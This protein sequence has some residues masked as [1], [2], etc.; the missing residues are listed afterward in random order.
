MKKFLPVLFLI[1]LLL[2]GCA[3]AASPVTVTVMLA[4][5]G[6]FTVDGEN[7]M[8]VRPG[9]DAVFRLSLS[10]D[11]VVFDADGGVWDEKN[12]TLTVPAVRFPATLS[13]R[14]IKN[15]GKVLFK[16]GDITGKGTLRT[17]H[18]IG[19]Y[20]RGTEITLEAEA[21]E[22]WI[23]A[24]WKK[25]YG[26]GGQI[27]STD[28]V[29]AFTLEEN[30][31]LTPQFLSENEAKKA[32]QVNILY[33]ANG[34][35]TRDGGDI[36]MHTVTLGIAKLPNLLPEQGYFKRDGHILIEYNTRA[37]GTGTGYSLGSKYIAGEGEV[38][39]TLYCIWA[40]ESDASLFKY[41]TEGGKA[42]ITSY[43]GN[44]D[45]VVIPSKLGGSPVT[46]IAKDAFT[47]RK[48]HTVV[49]PESM[50]TVEKGAFTGCPNFTTLY[51]FDTVEMIADNSFTNLSKF[52]NFRLNAAM[53][54]R[55]AGS[56]E[57][58]F[59]VKWEKLVTTQEKN[60]VVVMSGSSS[61]YGLS[62][63]LF[64]ELLGGKYTVVNYG[65]NAGTSSSFYMEVCSH[66]MHEGDILIQ[67][68][69][70]SNS[71]QHGINEITWRLLRGTE[72]YYNVFRLVDM[73]QYT[74]LFSAFTDYNNERK[75]MKDSSYGKADS[76]MDLNGDIIKKWPMNDEKYEWTKNSTPN[77]N[78]ITATFKK[79]LD[80]VHK[81]L[82]D[83]GATVYFSYGISNRNSYKDSALTSENLAKVDAGY[84]KQLTVP[85]ISKIE[86]YI[87]EGKYMANSSAHLND[88]GRTIRTQRLARD[89]LA[90]LEKDG[91]K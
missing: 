53:N 62:T 52:A 35:K 49:F 31:Q 50:R 78:R 87:F 22:G 57:G 40:K 74:K 18:E 61:L 81:M 29:Y 90:Q 60:R 16:T 75:N 14:V 5:N 27:I 10:E 91:I 56:T 64:E 24:G 39:P 17:S 4:E 20:Y 88:A 46:V 80:R 47:S 19:S 25:G 34:G 82:Q 63:P 89:L 32:G 85:L 69:C 1:L 79:N 59:Y 12:A 15:P 8:R 58:N 66:Y 45:T 2:A 83:A 42:T 77:P 67:A 21:A 86:D 37:D 30:V 51:M 38:L 43:T 84:R 9:E 11:C 33:N 68:P 41:T 72:S 7:P 54:P 3:A 71:N 28:P 26:A 44:E 13:P 55:F 36:Y 6:N 76:G 65:T 48:F 23:F 70:P 73:T